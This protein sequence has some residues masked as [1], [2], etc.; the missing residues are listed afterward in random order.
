MSLKNKLAKKFKD[1][2]Y[3]TVELFNDLDFIW[4]ICTICGAGYGTLNPEH[5]VCGE[6]NCVGRYQ[7]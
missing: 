2:K 3:Y 4:K 7:F 5:T 6:T 1:K